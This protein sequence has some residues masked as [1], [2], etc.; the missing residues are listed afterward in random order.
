MRDASRKAFK[1]SIYSL[2]P[3]L[4]LLDKVNIGMTVL[5]APYPHVF[6]LILLMSAHQIEVVWS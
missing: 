1:C 2:Q 6:S 3:C 4:S 5:S